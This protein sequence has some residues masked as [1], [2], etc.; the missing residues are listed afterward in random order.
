MRMTMTAVVCWLV[1]GMAAVGWADEAS[2][3]RCSGG[4]AE[5]LRFIEDSLEERRPYARY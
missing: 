3:A 2:F 5:R 1:L 4:T